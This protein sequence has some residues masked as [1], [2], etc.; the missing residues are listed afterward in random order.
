MS[1]KIHLVLGAT[2]SIGSAVTAELLRR[3][4]RVRV[5]VRDE[6][7]V[8]AL[9]P[10]AGPHLEVLPG[11]ATDPDARA[12][13]FSDVHTCYNGLNLPYPQWDRLPAIH[14]AVVQAAARA[15]ARLAF[16]GNV[17]VYGHPQTRP[18]RED[19][20]LAAHTRKGRIRMQIEEMLW[21]AHRRGDVPVTILRLPDFYGPNVLNPLVEPAFVQALT[22]KGG[23]VLCPGNPD[24][25]HELV[26]IRDAA[27][28]MVDVAS[29]EE[30]FGQTFHLPGPG[31]ITLRRWIGRIFEVAGAARPR[32]LAAGRTLTA[33][34]G[35]FDP[36]ARELRE[37]LYLWEEP[38]ILDGT[39]YRN[40]FGSYPA[41][42]YDEGIRQTLAWFRAREAGRDSLLEATAS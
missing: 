34:A 36:G 16:P 26:F 22:G 11:S 19:H 41:T 35:L 5:L 27:Q 32:I 17:Y 7:R 8:S 37:M 18:V 28:A 2:G 24:A 4:E 31:P 21:E 12:V 15:G 23:Q 40:A 30:A 13:A 14:R 6:T 3:G 29:R 38:L 1:T 42:P 39:R 25:D 33:L 10:S 9:F 20:P